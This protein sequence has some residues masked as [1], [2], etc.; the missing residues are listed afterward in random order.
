MKDV[1]GRVQVSKILAC[2]STADR[3]EHFDVTGDCIP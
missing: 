1:K 2:K 3:S